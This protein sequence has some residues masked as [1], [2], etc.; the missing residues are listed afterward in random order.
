MNWDDLQSERFYSPYNAY[1]QSKLADLLFWY[2]L[3]ALLCDTLRA[4]SLT[5]RCSYELHRRLQEKGSKVR[6][7]ACHPGVVLTPLW[8]HMPWWMAILM[9]G[10]R[11]LM[12]V[13]VAPLTRS[14]SHNLACFYILHSPSCHADRPPPERQGRCDDAR[15]VGGGRRGRGTQRQIL[16]RVQGEALEP[17]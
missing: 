12:K 16:H 15:V 6:V 2:V 13:Y 1:M 8:R 14:A 7:N 11:P 5:S 17:G 9:L 4:H 10:M 3:C